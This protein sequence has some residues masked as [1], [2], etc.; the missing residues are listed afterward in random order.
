[1][2]GHELTAHFYHV[3]ADGNWQEPAQ[4]HLARVRGSGLN[5]DRFM[6][7][8]VGTG[9]RL[10]AARKWLES[11]GIDVIAVEDEGYEQVTLSYARSWAA[12][13]DPETPVLYAHTK[14]AYNLSALTRAH[15]EI[16]SGA[17]IEQ[18]RDAVEALKDHDVAG[19]MWTPAPRPHFTGNF[20]WARAGYLAGLP[21]LSTA[22]RNEAELWLGLGDPR[23]HDMRAGFTYLDL[24]ATVYGHPEPELRG[25]PPVP[26]TAPLTYSDPQP[27]NS[28]P[29]HG[30]L[31]GRW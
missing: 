14:G 21:E 3:W 20:W 10:R 15:R 18:W 9:T 30:L 19:V 4:S 12:T 5:P 11:R 24:V 8:V 28:P 17:V 2:A 16:M 27:F 22:N 26:G 6:A 1:M 25:T 23:V 31:P 7:G 13:V 29:P